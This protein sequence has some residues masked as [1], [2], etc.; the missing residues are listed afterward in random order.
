MKKRLSVFLYCLCCWDAPAA[1]RQ[2]REGTADGLNL[3][4]PGTG[5]WKDLED[6]S[7]YLETTSPEFLHPE[8]F[9]LSSNLDGLST[10]RGTRAYHVGKDGIPV[11]DE[12][13]LAAEAYFLLKTKNDVPCKL[14]KPDGTWDSERAPKEIYAGRNFRWETICLIFPMM[15]GENR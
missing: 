15:H 8:H 4:L 11:A 13:R 10:Y 2:F 6:G 14:V 1:E 12:P 9:L 3:R 7:V 5:T